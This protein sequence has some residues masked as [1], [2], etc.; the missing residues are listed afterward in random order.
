MT[1]AEALARGWDYVPLNDRADENLRQDRRKA[2]ALIE[3][4]NLLGSYNNLS[5]IIPVYKFVEKN[6]ILQNEIAIKILGHFEGKRWP[7]I[8]QALHPYSIIYEEGF[9]QIY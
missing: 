7:D 9:C 4:K 3:E 8:E 5:D 6:G 2:K 1:S